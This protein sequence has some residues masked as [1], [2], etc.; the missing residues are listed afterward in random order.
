MRDD[1]KSLYVKVSSLLSANP[2]LTLQE[3]AR[4][5]GADRHKV[6]RA[7]KEQCGCCFREQKGSSVKTSLDP[8]GGAAQQL[9]ER[10]RRLRWPYRSSI[11]R[12]GCLHW[13]R[14]SSGIAVIP[15]A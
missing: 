9:P 14:L 10:S 8:L 13:Y 7:I 1:M 12:N 6:E 5:A 3:I 2:S 11:G 4:T 15:R